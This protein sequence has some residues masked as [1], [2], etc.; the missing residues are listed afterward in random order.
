[1]DS[2]KII[3]MTIK[4]DPPNTSVSEQNVF[5]NIRD[6]L[7]KVAFV[8]QYCVDKDNYYTDILG[9]STIIASSIT[10]LTVALKFMITNES[11]YNIV[12][13]I[14]PIIL[15]LITSI[16][17]YISKRYNE[18]I[19]KNKYKDYLTKVNNMLGMLTLCIITN[20][21]SKDDFDILISND[22]F[23]NDLL[24]IFKNQPNISK[25]EQDS[26]LEAYMEYQNNANS[27]LKISDLE[28]SDL[29]QV[30]D[31]KSK[32]PITSILDFYNIF[33]KKKI[34]NLKND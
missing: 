9:I 25:A 18:M 5:I 29:E 11:I 12:K 1:M 34:N 24:Y 16:I 13:D 19:I 28:I 22:N 23:N 27:E 6:Y 3:S 10:S 8:Y 33:N 4:Y 20:K 30:F 26:A 2:N 14:N 32:I 21:M 17:T 31:S 7:E 15:G